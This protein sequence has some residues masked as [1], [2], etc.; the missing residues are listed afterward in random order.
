M[1]ID[2][3]QVGPNQRQIMTIG[4]PITSSNLGSVLPIANGTSTSGLFAP[5][6]QG[7]TLLKNAGNT[8][9]SAR[10]TPGITG[11]QAVSTEGLKTTYSVGSITFT[12]AATATDIW[13]L[14]GSSTTT[15]RLL[16]LE[17]S[18]IATAA[19]TVEIQLIKRTTAD[20]AGTSAS[21]TPVSHDKN[22]AAATA[23]VNLYS[24]NPT[25]GTGAGNVR[26]G[27][28][29]LGAAGAAGLLVWDFGTRN[30]QGVVLR[31]VAEGLCL[32]WN[33]AAVPSGTLL[34]ISAEFVE[35]LS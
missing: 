26:G 9:D 20:T 27:K 30:S 31:G 19:A 32:N 34:C 33:G 13:T 35:D 6:T 7:A 15:V 17:I 8:F 23:T 25:L 2:S 10:S 16:R 29:N 18:G 14:F 21:L 24:A 22:N 11:V 3:T 28:L 1:P 12:P 4:D 5:L